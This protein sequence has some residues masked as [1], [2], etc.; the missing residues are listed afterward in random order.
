[1]WLAFRFATLLLVPFYTLAQPTDPIQHR[2]LLRRQNVTQP[3]LRNVY[4]IGDVSPTAK[5]VSA[6]TGK[7]I[8]G[9]HTTIHIDGTS[10]DG[11]LRVQMAFVPATTQYTISVKDW[12]VANTGKPIGFWGESNSRRYVVQTG[13]T[14]FTNAN[15]LNHQTGKGI[16]TTAWAENPIYRR[17]GGVSSH[18]FME[19]AVRILA[20]MGLVLDP[21]M[22]PLFDNSAEYFSDSSDEY[23]Q[24]V[25]ELLSTQVTSEDDP[26]PSSDSQRMFDIKEEPVLLGDSTDASAAAAACE[27]SRKRSCAPL[28]DGWDSGVLYDDT[29]TQEEIDELSATPLSEEKLLPTIEQESR[30]AAAPFED[31]FGQPGTATIGAA[32]EIGMG[33][34]GGALTAFAMIGFDV[35]KALAQAAGPLLVLLD[36]VDGNWVGA[37]LAAVGVALGIAASLAVAGPV[38]WIFGGIITAFFFILPLGK[39]LSCINSSRAVCRC[40]RSCFEI[41]TILHEASSF[42]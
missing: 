24:E 42:S 9:M 33:R 37:G 7:T 35:A 31:T 8:L 10:S 29:I 15:I 23:V 26:D 18:T 34:T 27:K 20:F 17:G 5:A 13:A 16:V 25:E 3:I 22:V 30:A 2:H 41:I 32:V 6:T 12:G 40:H 11:P 4:I 39:S 28:P 36:M 21:A 19:V 14:N 1:M 38:G